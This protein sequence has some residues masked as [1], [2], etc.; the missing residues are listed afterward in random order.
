M[1]TTPPSGTPRRP[2]DKLIAMAAAEPDPTERPTS[3]FLPA[4]IV[5]LGLLAVA[6]AMLLTRSAGKSDDR[7]EAAQAETVSLAEQVAGEC[8]TG[9]LT[10]PVCQRATQVITTTPGPPGSPGDPGAP[11][12]PGTRGP[13]GPAGPAGVTGQQGVAGVAGQTGAVG[14]TGAAGPVGPAGPAGQPG[15]DGQ[16]GQP[17]QDGQPP[18][19]W[20]VDNGD[21]TTSTC[22]RNGTTT[23]YSCAADGPPPVIAVPPA[24]AQALALAPPAAPAS[25]PA[26]TGERKAPKATPRR[27]TTPAT[28]KPEPLNLPP[29]KLPG[30]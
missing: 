7:A 2:S 6:G 24:P 15:Q 12:V 26:A 19:G 3:R 28:Q 30:L 10:G 4:V 22:T 1:T 21:G 29:L 23:T 27:K 25:A 14:A 9:R 17:G 16:Q 11:G 5:A 18:A 13:V 20:T 8:G